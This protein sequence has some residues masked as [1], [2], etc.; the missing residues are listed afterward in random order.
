MAPHVDGL[1]RVAGARSRATL[2]A[3]SEAVSGRSSAPVGA[4]PVHKGLPSV[5]RDVLAP[6]PGAIKIKSGRSPTATELLSLCVLKEKVTKEK[7]HPAS[8][9]YGHRATA[10]GVASTP[11]SMP[12]PARKVRG[13]VTGF[14][15]RASCPGAK[16]A[17]I[18][19]GQPAGFPS[20]ARRCRGA[21][22][23]AAGHPGPH[24]VIKLK[25]KGQS[26]ASVCRRFALDPVLLKSADQE[27]PLLYRGPC[28]AVRRGRQAAQRALPGMA[29]PF[30]AGRSPLEKPGPG[31]RTCWAGCPTSAKRGG[32]SLWL[33]FSL[34]TQRESNSPSEGGRKLFAL[35][36]KVATRT[37]RKT[38]PARVCSTC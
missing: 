31:S 17:G 5:V 6:A 9:P 8:A 1:D 11:A 10:P 13:R 28:A 7:E 3:S 29:T 37:S 18:P 35:K 38:S 2:L 24:S 20:P 21:P 36:K 15:D 19:A 33:S 30:R 27:G 4:H 32:L 26:K 12:S 25:N 16:L 23:K 22:G 14:V 34:A